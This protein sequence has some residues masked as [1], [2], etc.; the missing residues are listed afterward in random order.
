MTAPSYC[1]V[2]PTVGRPSLA[3]LL[4]SLAG[5][6]GPLPGQIVVVD[7]RRAPA[8]LPPPPSRLADLVTVRRSGG[9]GP[10]AARNVGWRATDPAGEWVV[11]LDDDVVVR[12]DWLACVLRDLDQGG[13][14]GGVQGVVTVPLPGDRRATDWERGTRGLET[15]AWI[16][17][18]MAYRRTVLERVGGF[19]ERFPRA[20]REDADLALRVL[21]TG[22]ELRRGSREVTHP[23]RPAD[24]WV[25]VRV[26]AGNADD[27]LM[28]RMHGSDWRRLAMAPAGRRRGH[29]LVTATACTAIAA[30]AAGRRV[31]AMAAAATWLVGTARFAW[32]RIAP[33][34]RR[35]DEVTTMVVT[36]AVIPPVATWHWLRGVW[37]HRSAPPWATYPAR[38]VLF[39]R[40]GT[41]IEDVPYNGDPSK[42]RPMDGAVQLV[43]ELRARGVRT[44][45]ITNQSAI[46]R[47]RLT[48]DQVHRVNVHVDQIFGGFDVWAVCPHVD[49]DDCACRKP[50]PGMVLQAA[51]ALGFSPHEIAVIGDIGADV[52]AAA[53]AGARGILVPTDATRPEE[54]AA[55]PRVAADL[56]EAVRLAVGTTP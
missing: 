54:V 28:R 36:S 11:F 22:A 16:T 9:R 52:E 25:S 14:V 44:G 37:R 34:P 5:A 1:I 43:A 56:S 31:L 46:G 29:L 18:D 13:A 33:G 3:V 2:I 6:D 4:E 32:A 42:V 48:W 38:A 23:V 39:D 8:E 35:R 21:R 10:A 51:A 45:V 17:A 50:A 30:A 40:D 15:A 7:D 53:A 24:R 12:R 47:G 55:A 19:D 26:Q 49:D 20:F 41:L 27:A